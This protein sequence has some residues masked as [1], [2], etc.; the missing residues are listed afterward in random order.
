LGHRTRQQ[1]EGAVIMS[2]GYSL[3]EELRFQGGKILD[4][5]FDTCPIPRW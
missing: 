2:L 5:N 4:R 3:A 1:I